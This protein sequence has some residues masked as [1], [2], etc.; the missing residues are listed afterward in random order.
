MCKLLEK[1]YNHLKNR[2][3]RRLSVSAYVAKYD[4]WSQIV[5]ISLKTVQ[6][7][8]FSWTSQTKDCLLEIGNDRQRPGQ[9]CVST[10]PIACILDPPHSPTSISSTSRVLIAT[11]TSRQVDLYIISLQLF[12]GS[13]YSEVNRVKILLAYLFFLYLRLIQSTSIF[14]LI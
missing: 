14:G 12:C 5:Y 13:P 4:S 7:D 8:T 10:F 9:G 3:Y 6:I 2:M 1:N 11:S